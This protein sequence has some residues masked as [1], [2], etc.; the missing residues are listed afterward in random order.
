MEDVPWNLFMVSRESTCYP[1]GIPINHLKTRWHDLI[2][3]L[4]QFITCE[5]RYGLVFLYHVRFLML[6]IGFDLNMSFYFLMSLYKMSKH[7]KRHSMNSMS[8]LFHHML[9]KIMVISHLSQ[10]RDNWESFLSRNGF[11]QADHTVN[12][13]LNVNPSFDSLVT[14]SQGFNS[15]D[16]YEI[17]EFVSIVLKT[18]MVN[19]SR[20]IFSPRKSLE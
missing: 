13:P 4:K 19:K 6:F 10:I 16:G 17:N 3:I 7:F 9:I 5:G 20:C 2:L 12:L 8:S 1:K 11:S 14:E 18:P 15:P